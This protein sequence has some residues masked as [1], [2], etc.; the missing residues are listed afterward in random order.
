LRDRSDKYKY[1]VENV[2]DIKDLVAGRV[3]LARW[4][5]F[6][7]VEKVIHS[8]FFV[9]TFG[10]VF[11]VPS[12][13]SRL[14]LPRTITNKKWP[15]QLSIL[16]K[17]SDSLLAGALLRQILKLF[18]FQMAQKFEFVCKLP[19]FYPFYLSTFLPFYLSTFLPF[20]LSTLTTFLPSLPFYSHYPHYLLPATSLATS[21]TTSLAISLAICSSTS[22]TSLHRLSS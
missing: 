13:I 4:A 6:E 18:K 11:I 5:D 2:G 21:L 22:L 20:Y 15:T 9:S 14:R 7:N 8:K 17:P 19:T 3:I 16:I 12:H 1:E 10:L